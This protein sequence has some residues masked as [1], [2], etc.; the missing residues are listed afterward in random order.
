MVIT[1]VSKFGLPAQCTRLTDLGS[2]MLVLFSDKPSVIWQFLQC[3][4]QRQACQFVEY[5]LPIFCPFLSRSKGKLM[6]DS[7]CFKGY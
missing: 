5:V 2:R 6:L 1:Y 4:K 3:S 7:V